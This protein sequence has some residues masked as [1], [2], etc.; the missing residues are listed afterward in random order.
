M[1]NEMFEEYIICLH[2]YIYN[3]FLHDTLIEK[4]CGV[5]HDTLIEKNCGVIF[6]IQ[7]VQ[8]VYT[9]YRNN[10]FYTHSYSDR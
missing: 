4:N 6:I 8:K 7:D 1:E 9:F 10:I 3:W 2:H 5:L